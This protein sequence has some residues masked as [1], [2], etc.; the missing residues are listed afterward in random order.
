[1][2]VCR[3][4][5]HIIAEIVVVIA[6][7]IL[8][9][10]I[11]GKLPL[12]V[13]MS[14]QRIFSLSEQS[15]QTLKIIDNTLEI[16]VFYES[17]EEQ[18]HIELL[19]N[20]YEKRAEGRIKLYFIDPEI[21][22]IEA[23]SW[24]T[25]KSG[26]TNGDIIIRYGDSSIK[27]TEYQMIEKDYYGFINTFS[28]EQKITGAIRTLVEEN[29]PVI[30]FLEGHEEKSIN[31]TLLSLKESLQ[32]SAWNVDEIN[33]L[34]TD[35][36][37]VEFDCL[38]IP[39]PKRDLSSAETSALSVYLNRGGRAL[40]MFDISSKNE[41]LINF[42]H[43]LETFGIKIENSIV[44]EESR[45]GYYSE[46]KMYIVPSI[47]NHEIVNS[48]SRKN[49]FALLP[50][51][52]N[53]SIENSDETIDAV[54]LLSSSSESW[55]RTDMTNSSIEMTDEDD[56]G[57]A[58]LAVA[59]NKNNYEDKYPE[60]R[61]V[62]VGNAKFIEDE[63]LNIQGNLDFFMNS[64]SW[65]NERNDFMLISPKLVNPDRMYLQ[66]YQYIVLIIISAVIIPL[67]PFIAG[68][69]IWFKRRNL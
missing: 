47:E 17:G 9:N 7:I 50:F 38:V 55:I 58:V 51:S 54:P 64:L 13:D 68:L 32:A 39:A 26:I 57:P 56:A 41:E 35:I 22:P 66:G 67:L 18:P 46:N 24:D 29:L 45:G 23:N 42:H 28:G 31:T 53:I 65:L 16:A 27:L 10:L 15:L 21:N 20:E 49:L 63:M 61:M 14:A 30:V 34:S 8:I 37:S 4:I 52:R 3:N 33:L 40:F 11:A 36:N 59:V 44:V 2:K 69:F 48:L 5:L 19:L 1:M 62:A 60:T 6:I 43:L 25:E 12:S